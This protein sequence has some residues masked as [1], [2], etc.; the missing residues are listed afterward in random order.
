MS[1]HGSLKSRHTRQRRNVL[2]RSE[3]IK[4]LKAGKK[5]KSGNSLYGLPKVKR[6]S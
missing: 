2:K 1:I 4:L 6:P 3:R 5:W